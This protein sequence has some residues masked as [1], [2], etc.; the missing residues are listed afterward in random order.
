[1]RIDRSTLSP[2]PGLRLRSLPAAA[3]RQE[4]V[5]AQAI[6]RQQP[7]VVLRSHLQHLRALLAVATVAIVGLTAAVA[8]L[9]TEENVD[10]SGSSENPLSA[11]TPKERHRV[12]ALSSLSPVQLAAAFGRGIVPAPPPGTPYDGDPGIFGSPPGTPYDGDP[13]IFGPRPRQPYD[14]DPGIFGPRPSPPYDGDWGFLPAPPPRASFA[15]E[16]KDEADLPAAITQSSGRTESRGSNASEAGT[17]A[18]QPTS[19]TRP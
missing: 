5:I 7:A 10:S 19:S 9:V 4:A 1:V 14:G 11:L 15:T 16:M 12:E 6:P 3:L 8:I 13:G 18:G 17:S 2:P